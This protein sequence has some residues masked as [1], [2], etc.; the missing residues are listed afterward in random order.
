MA[1]DFSNVTGVLSSAFADDI[2]NQINRATPL[3]QILSFRMGSEKNIQW[4]VRFG[5]ATGSTIADGADVSTYN[6]DDLVP[7]TL[8]FGTY[9]DAFSVTGKAMAAA[10]AAGNPDQ[11][12]DLMGEEM[13]HSV[14]RL[15]TKLSQDCYT[16]AGGTNE[17]HG[18]LHSSGGVSATGTY[19]SINRATYTQWASNSVDAAAAALSLAQLRQTRRAIYLASGLKPDVIICDPVA[20]DKYGALLG[21]ERRYM[22]DVR[23]RGQTV[24]LD[25]GYQVLEF[26]GTP[27]IEDKQMS[28][29]T[30][31]FLNSRHVYLT[32]LPNPASVLA[33]A[34]G[35]LMVTG[36]EEMQFGVA[37]PKLSAMVLPLAVTGNAFKV[38]LFAHPQIVVRRPNSCGKLINFT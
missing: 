14:E 19:A 13:S 28:A 25:G 5:T 26:E 29:D 22:Q 9:H 30:F 15:A 17:I 37:S 7:A 20:F 33:R 36:T 6:T 11:L 3:F 23:L 35:E 31:L 4:D 1:R 32:Q 21:S 2:T 38:G 18:M 27:V 8:Q 12:V 10:A 16:G 34:N 24:V